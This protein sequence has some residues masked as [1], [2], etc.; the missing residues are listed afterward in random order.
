MPPVQ[1]G[2]ADY[3]GAW[4]AA[5]ATAGVQVC[6]PPCDAQGRWPAAGDRWW[7]QVDRVHAEL[8]GG[9]TREFLQLE[10][11]AAAGHTRLSATVHDPHRLVWRDPAPG[12]WQ[13]RAARWPRPLP[14]L[15]ALA[16]DRR[17]LARERALGSRLS[18]LV[19]LTRTGAQGLCQR[20]QLPADKVHCIAH[21]NA[22]I[23]PRP[24]PRSGRLDLLYFGFIYPGKGIETLFH[25]LARVRAA[26]PQAALRLT[27]AGG[28]APELTFAGGGGYLA[29]LQALATRL[30][31]DDCLHW[32][33]DLP[34][35]DIV[36]CIQSHQVM[37]LP[38]RQSWR[39]GLLGRMQGTSG[40]LSWAS[41]CGRGV[42]ATDTRSFAEE[43]SH[44]NGCVVAQG[45]S[46]AM[47]T[48]ITGLLDDP[49]RAAA[50]AAQAAALGRQRRWEIV[51]GR[52]AALF[53]QLQESGR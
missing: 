17:T 18:A 47:A 14:Q 43:L 20:M 3:A 45:D 51:A 23:A 7:Q 12:P 53:A 37:V 42:I 33:L 4:A 30:G 9:R 39:I 26:R 13:Q 48:A 38:Y 31:I 46:A 50:W 24:L 1:S 35:A 8:G 36:D 2:I 15:A 41:A 28:T 34:A 29:Q 21:G 5:L 6:T 27:L 22:D 10:Q 44:G 11:L 40:A 32:Q 16:V 49:E 25:A 52:F 19:T